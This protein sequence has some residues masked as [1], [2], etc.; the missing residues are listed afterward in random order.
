LISGIACDK[1]AYQTVIVGF[2]FETI[3][4]QLSRNV[5]MKQVLDFFSKK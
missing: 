1:G 2:P 4:S 3:E 5:M